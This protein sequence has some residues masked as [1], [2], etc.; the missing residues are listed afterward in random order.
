MATAASSNLSLAKLP[1]AGRV[2]FGVV[3]FLL[4]GVLYYVLL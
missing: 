4:V 1:P 3:A 2:A